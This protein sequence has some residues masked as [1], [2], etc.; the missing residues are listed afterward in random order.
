MD[1]MG[2]RIR[3]G[4]IYEGSNSVHFLKDAARGDYVNF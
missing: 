1:E 2:M 3:V 4:R